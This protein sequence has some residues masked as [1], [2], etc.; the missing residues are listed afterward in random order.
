MTSLVGDGAGAAT[1]SP[2]VFVSHASE[3]KNRFVRN[4]A[5]RLRAAGIDAWFDQWEI[6]AGDSLV[7]RIE[8][9]IGEAEAFLVVLSRHSIDKPWVRIELDAAVIRSIES[10]TKLIP[11]RLD[12]VAVPP[13]LSTKKWVSVPDVTEYDD[14]FAEICRSIFEIDTRPPLGLRP[15]YAASTGIP[16]LNQA[17]SAVLLTLAGV[18][19]ETG[20]P[21]ADYQLSA[22]RSANAGIDKGGFDLSLDALKLAGFVAFERHYGGYVQ[23]PE[24]LPAAWKLTLPVLYPDFRKTR[25]A[26]IGLLVNELAPPPSVASEA[27]A[28]RLE[29][30]LQ[31][32]VVVLRELER[33]E[34]VTLGWGTHNLVVYRAHPLLARELD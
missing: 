22:E 4:L 30:P 31:V 12:D 34:Q 26:L 24:L 8:Q 15:A 19:I 9:G 1:P 27:L 16:G 28:D 6:A 17:D 33:A 13:L 20:S 14:A 2:K 10:Q 32:V 5:T 23:P 21:R 25:R 18:A 29:C 7:Q 11:I 3:D